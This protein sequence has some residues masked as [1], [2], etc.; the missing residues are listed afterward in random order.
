MRADPRAVAD[1]IGRP[2][3]QAHRRRRPRTPD[4]RR[5]ITAQLADRRSPRRPR[6]PR[7]PRA[8]PARRSARPARSA[9]FRRS[10][11][12]GSPRRAGSRPPARTARAARHRHAHAAPDVHAAVDV[13][14]AVE[15]EERPISGGVCRAARTPRP[16][17]ARA[18]R[19]RP[20]RSNPWRAAIT[21]RVLD[22]ERAVALEH[23]RRRGGT[24]R[25]TSSTAGGSGSG[26]A[27]LLVGVADQ[28]R[29][30]AVAELVADRAHLV[31]R[32]LDLPR[33]CS[34]CSP[35]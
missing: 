17:R 24:R 9:P 26:R 10:P 8:P 4:R 31:V 33:C 13:D 5:Q 23:Q 11:R 12:S 21:L 6:C 19:A 29:L 1:P 28:H 7:R 15:L 34:T 20:S 3:L 30:G 27:R 18:R 2:A 14:P 22:P 16:A 35:R 32:G 25:S